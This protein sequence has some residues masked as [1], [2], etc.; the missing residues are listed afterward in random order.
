MLLLRQGISCVTWEDFETVSLGEYGMRELQK[1]NLGMI[2]SM[3]M[4]SGVVRFKEPPDKS[5][6]WS[7]IIE[8]KHEMD[9]W[10]IFDHWEL[11][12]RQKGFQV[13]KD[14]G[15]HNDKCVFYLE[16]DA[17]ESIEIR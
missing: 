6:G 14:T 10:R 1:I 4:H 13:L 5:P 11:L 8:L 2:I 12:F 7:G 16:K 9:K 15:K 3:D 17:V